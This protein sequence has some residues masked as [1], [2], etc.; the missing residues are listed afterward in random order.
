MST[1]KSQLGQ[2]ILTVITFTLVLGTLSMIW[3]GIMAI[4]FGVLLLLQSFGAEQEVVV[5]SWTEPV[6]W[7][8]VSAFLRQHEISVILS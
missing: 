4:F 8:V 1:D 2:V 6:H 7:S 3:P 5:L